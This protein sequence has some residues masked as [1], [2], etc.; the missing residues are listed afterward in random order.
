MRRWVVAAGRP[1]H[2]ALGADG[3]ALVVVAHP[4]DESFGLGAV[5]SALTARGVPTDVLCLTRGEASTL[6]AA[7]GLGDC[8]AVEVR[9]AAAELGVRRLRLLDHPDG[10]LADLP[11]EQLATDVR[12]VAAATGARLL[13]VFDLGG[14]TGHPDHHRATEAA[15]AARVDLPVLAWAIGQS[16]AER[17]NA[18]LGTAFVGRPPEQLDLAMVVDR[19][20]QMRAV[21][22][23]RTQ[24]IDNPV[25]RRRLELQGDHEVLRWLRPPVSAAVPAP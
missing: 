1:D 2:A 6:G 5:V 21:A 9:R 16:V 22:C 4:D 11:I 18:E 23:H 24:S 10:G 7:P 12:Q 17:L 13:L 20:S 15:L 25:L 14:V 8:R 3:P 19:A